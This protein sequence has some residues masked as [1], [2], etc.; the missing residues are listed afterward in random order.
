MLTIFIKLIYRQYTKRLSCIYEGRVTKSRSWNIEAV[1]RWKWKNNVHKSKKQRN[2]RKTDERSLKREAIL[3]GSVRRG[4]I[5]L[6][7]KIIRH[8]CVHVLVS[9]RM[10][11]IQRKRPKKISRQEQQCPRIIMWYIYGTVIRYYVRCL[12]ATYSRLQL[13]VFVTLT[14]DETVCRLVK[15]AKKGLMGLTPKNAHLSKRLGIAKRKN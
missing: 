14:R 1:R 3:R 9:T 2:K 12:D 10:T 5:R 6:R 15:V 11:I 13:R 4:K 8:S 7:D